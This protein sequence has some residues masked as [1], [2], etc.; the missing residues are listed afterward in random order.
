MPEIDLAIKAQGAQVRICQ[1]RLGHQPHL[2][3]IKHLNRLEQVLAQNE[4]HNPDIHE[5]LLF[6]EDGRLVSGTKSNVFLVRAGTLITPNL[7]RCGVAGVTRAR[8]MKI[9][10]DAGLPGGEVDDIDLKMVLAADELLLCNSLIGLWRVARLEDRSWHV[11]V[12]YSYLSER[13]HA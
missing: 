9:A 6:D 10:H 8:L 4:W 1:L 2:A 13:L 11:P 3:G 12:L 7:S 5:G